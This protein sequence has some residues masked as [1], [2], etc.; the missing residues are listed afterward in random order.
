MAYE[1]TA[2]EQAAIVRVTVRGAAKHEEHLAAR[3][4]AGQACQARG[5]PRMLVDLREMETSGGL[6]T[7]GCFEFG[8][9][10]RDAG[11]PYACR[12]ACV[13]PLSPQ[14]RRDVEFT[15]TV[16]MNRGIILRNFTDLGEAQR[17]LAREE[18]G[19]AEGDTLA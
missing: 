15:T 2:D 8:T 14:A 5:W 12:L 16:G 9:T 10:Y 11:V 4:E 3:R 6:T 18:T 19:V 17:W 7:A 13:L 1:V